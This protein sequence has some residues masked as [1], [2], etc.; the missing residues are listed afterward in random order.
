M[1]EIWKKK[2]KTLESFVEVLLFFFFFHKNNE[3]KR[4]CNGKKKTSN[5]TMA[6]GKEIDRISKQIVFREFRNGM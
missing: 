4:I 5:L 6:E 3:E 2:Q 1:G